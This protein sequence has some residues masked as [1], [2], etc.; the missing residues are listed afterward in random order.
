MKAIPTGHPSA[1]VLISVLAQAVYCCSMYTLLHVHGAQ[2]SFLG[3]VV[4]RGRSQ[5]PL[6]GPGPFPS[7][8]HP[9]CL[10]FRL[11]F[12]IH[13]SGVLK[14]KNLASFGHSETVQYIYLM[15]ETSNKC[16]CSECRNNPRQKK[17]MARRRIPKKRA[18]EVASQV[19]EEAVSPTQFTREN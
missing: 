12:V 11:P 6:T 10:Q 15:S 1:A 18:R 19:K 3:C 4:G 9:L 13:A 2:P 14:S 7:L 5:S 8:A 17:T 16:L